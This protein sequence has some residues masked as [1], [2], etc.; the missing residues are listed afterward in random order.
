VTPVSSDFPDG[1][2]ARWCLALATGPRHDRSGG[3]DQRKPAS[4]PEEATGRFPRPGR[5]TGSERGRGCRILHDRDGRRGGRWPLLRCRS[6]RLA[7]HTP[8]LPAIMPGQGVDENPS[9][10]AGR[11]ALGPN[12][13]RR[14]LYSAEAVSFNGDRARRIISKEVAPVGRRAITA[15]LPIG[16]PAMAFPQVG[17]GLRLQ[18]PRQTPSCRAINNGC[19]RRSHRRPRSD[20]RRSRRHR[21]SDR[22]RSRH[23]HRC[24]L[25]GAWPR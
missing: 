18:T 9:L 1:A 10:G 13:H 7:G 20:H 8:S 25:H 23:R 16:S 2:R 15:M 14:A 6:P 21:R 24:E 4:G 22:R 5:A 17:R 12:C 11:A 3:S 19:R